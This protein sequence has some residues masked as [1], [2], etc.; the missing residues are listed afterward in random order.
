VRLAKI[1]TVEAA[2][3]FL[4]TSYI[5]KFNEQ[6]VVA[7]EEKETIFRPSVRSDL[8]WTSRYRRR[9]LMGDS[10]AVRTSSILLK[11]FFISKGF[12][13]TIAAPD[14]SRLTRPKA[15]AAT[16]ERRCAG[17]V[18]LSMYVQRPD[19]CRICGVGPVQRDCCKLR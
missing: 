2:N 16:A 4:R 14:R 10:E 11:R 13:M 12:W 1:T 18:L 9:G 17:S 6:F 3:E 15:G 7:A 8:N 5:A 19:S